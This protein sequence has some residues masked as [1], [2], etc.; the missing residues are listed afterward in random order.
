MQRQMEQ[1]VDHGRLATVRVT[2]VVPTAQALKGKHGG[3]EDWEKVIE[4]GGTRWD[5]SIKRLNTNPPGL[6]TCRQDQN[7]H[8]PT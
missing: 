1:R 7:C 5:A 2:E 4:E 8:G 3:V 6:K